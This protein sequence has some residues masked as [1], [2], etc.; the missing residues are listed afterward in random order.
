M[1]PRINLATIAV[2]CV[3]LNVGRAAAELPDASL[4]L[5]GGSMAVGVG[6]TWASATLYYKGK[7]YDVEA[8]GLSVPD[9]GATHLRA[10]LIIYNLKNLADFDG[11]YTAVAARATVGGGASAGTMTNQNGVRINVVS[12]TQGLKFTLAPAGVSLKIKK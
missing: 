9:L 1:A 11:N 4:I 8:S 3:L 7:T 2:L 10:S 6:I 5:S 12:T